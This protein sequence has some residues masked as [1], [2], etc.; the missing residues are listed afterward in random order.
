MFASAWLPWEN[1][2]FLNQPNRF[3]IQQKK[4]LTRGFCITRWYL[5]DSCCPYSVAK[6][7]CFPL[8]EPNK[9]TSHSQT[10]QNSCPGC[11][12][13][14]VSA[15]FLKPC[16]AKCHDAEVHGWIDSVICESAVPIHQLFADCWGETSLPQVELKDWQKGFWSFYL[17]TTVCLVVKFFLQWNKAHP[18]NQITE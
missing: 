1:I 8:K 11:G 9:W 7:P 18:R 4:M 17:H 14:W 15:L 12:I 2:D 16:C 5:E 13:W 6:T 3:S 10:G